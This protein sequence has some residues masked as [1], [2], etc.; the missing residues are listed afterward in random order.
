MMKYL[1]LMAGWFL[2]AVGMLIVLVV[3]AFAP[4]AGLTAAGVGKVF[5]VWILIGVLGAVIGGMVA[6]FKVKKVF[7]D[8]KE[9]VDDLEMDDP[10]TYTYLIQVQPLEGGGQIAQE[11]Q[12]LEIKAQLL[13]AGF[14]YEGEFELQEVPGIEM[15]AYVN[16]RRSQRAVVYFQAGKGTWMDVTSE[17]VGGALV[18]VTNIQMPATTDMRPGV[19][20]VGQP[21]ASVTEMLDLFEKNKPEGEL[22]PTPLGTFAQNMEKAWWEDKS[23]RRSRGGTTMDEARRMRGSGAVGDETTTQEQ[24]KT[25]VDMDNAQWAS[26]WSQVPGTLIDRHLTSAGLNEDDDAWFDRHSRLVAA[27]EGQSLD[28]FTEYLAERLNNLHS[29]ALQDQGRD[30]PEETQTFKP[31]GFRP[32]ADGFKLQ[33]ATQGQTDGLSAAKAIF[34]KHPEWFKEVFVGEHPM[35]H[36]VYEVAV[37]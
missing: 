12:A 10:G 9:M 27:F 28:E 3:V 31:S 4:F 33:A 34:E 30:D 32:G 1:G 6:Y 18:Y 24:L 15:A 21:G 23:W 36:G 25:A 20:R 29:L 7:S 2:I 14:E 13:E 8:I 22:A 19:T 16:P 26:A 11:P 5:G 17:L 37:K 35:R